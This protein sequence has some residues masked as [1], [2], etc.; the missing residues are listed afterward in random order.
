M[1]PWV[2]CFTTVF[3][4]CKCGPMAFEE[5]FE[6]QCLVLFPQVLI[7]VLLHGVDNVCVTSVPG[8]FF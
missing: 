5:S 2:H 3:I 6:W 1:V 8:K 4:N 7:L